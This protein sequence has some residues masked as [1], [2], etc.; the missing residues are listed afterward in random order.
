ME[1]KLSK[2]KT[3]LYGVKKSKNDSDAAEIPKTIKSKG[4]KQQLSDNSANVKAPNIT[5]VILMMPFFI[6]LECF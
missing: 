6:K 2:I 1:H 4:A 5:E 3:N